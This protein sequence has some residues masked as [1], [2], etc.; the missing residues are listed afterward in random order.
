MGLNKSLLAAAAARVA[1]FVPAVG[2]AVGLA[3]A[4]APAYADQPVSGQFGFQAAASPL[5]ERIQSFHDLMLVIITGITVF[6]LVLMLYV[7][8]RFR[9]SANP[10]P[11]RTSHNTLIEV[12]WTVAPVL[13]LVVIAVPSFRLLYYGDAAPKAEMTIKVTGHQWY[14]S[15]EYP[16]HGAFTFDSNMVQDADLKP[17]QPRLLT[18][19]NPLVVPV[20]TQVRVLTTSADVIHSF[21]MP[22]FGLQK[23][24]SPGRTNEAWFQADKIGTFYG[25]CNQICGVNHA[26]MPIAVEAVDAATFERWATEAKRRFADSGLPPLSVAEVMALEA[27]RVALNQTK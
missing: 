15:Y 14:W 21:F 27:P 9:E 4:G 23:Y 3:L 17:G 11:S 12:I 25:Q 22:S 19:D 26:F 18:A 8:F 13:I 16:D 6:V 1:G 7:M 24:A 10:T 2:A 5:M 20:G